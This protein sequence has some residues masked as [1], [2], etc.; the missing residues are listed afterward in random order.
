MSKLNINI[1]NHEQ[2]YTVSEMRRRLAQVLSKLNGDQEVTFT[3]TCTLKHYQPAAVAASTHSVIAEMR[4]DN[5]KPALEIA[6]APTTFVVPRL[7]LYRIVDI[8]REGHP[9][10]TG[11]RTFATREAAQA[12]VDELYARA[13]T[14]AWGYV[15]RPGRD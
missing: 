10:E 8:M 5:P 11:F 9:R 12:F 6:A 7:S 1:E 13:P 4:E 3:F 14:L 2:K 15:V